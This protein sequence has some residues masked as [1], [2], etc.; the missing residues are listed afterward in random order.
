TKKTAEF[1]RKMVETVPAQTYH[2][3]N[4]NIAKEYRIVSY[5]RLDKYPVVAIM[6]FGRNEAVAEWHSSAIKRG[7]IVGVLSLLII[8]LSRMLLRQLELLDQKVQERTSQLSLA[9]LFLEKEIQDR[10]EIEVDLLKHQQKMEEMAIEISLT[11]DRERSRIA[12]ELHDQ[13]GQRLILCK[14]KLDGLASGIADRESLQTVTGL[15][16]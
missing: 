2:N 3:S 12:G 10:R 9:N 13:V 16:S 14:I 15:E 7:L 4:S 5:N 1:F 8:I 6:S 11:E